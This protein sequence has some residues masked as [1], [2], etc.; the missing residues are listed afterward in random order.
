MLK[1]W[2][3]LAKAAK[4]VVVAVKDKATL[5]LE[6]T[7]TAYDKLV[8]LIFKTE[9][10]LHEKKEEL[11]TAIDDLHESLLDEPKEESAIDSTQKLA[12]KAAKCVVIAL[13]VAS[14]AALL[15][16]LVSV[17]AIWSVI[18]AIAKIYINFVS[19]EIFDKA[20]A[21]ISLI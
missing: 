6:K 7:L 19:G 13:E 5:V 9:S 20:M 12:S 11:K 14:T 3:N 4:T 1:F 8:N 10:E 17:L 15:S 16:A 2:I 18:S 21:F